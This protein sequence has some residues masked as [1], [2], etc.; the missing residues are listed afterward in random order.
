M[1]GVY[2]RVI[3]RAGSFLSPEDI[4]KFGEFRARVIS[5]NRMSLTMNRKMM[6]PG[7]K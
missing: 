2:Q 7:S 6:S 3:A 4:G 5:A 1:D